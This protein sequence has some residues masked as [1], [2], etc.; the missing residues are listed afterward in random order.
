M[1]VCANQFSWRNLGRDYVIEAFRLAQK[2]SPNAE[3]Y[4]ND[5][6]N[7]QPNKRAG[8]I[9]L[10]KKIQAAGVR[11]DGVGIQGHWHTANCSSKILKRVLLRMLH[12]V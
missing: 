4:Y 6:N 5:Y 12:W 10:I 7:E 11:I 8:C 1:A 2:A 3:L 9:A